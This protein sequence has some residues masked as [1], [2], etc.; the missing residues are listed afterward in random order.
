MSGGGEQADILPANYVVKDRWKVVSDPAGPREGLGRG[1]DWRP[2]QT[3][4]PTPLPEAG[5]APELICILLAVTI[6]AYT[7]GQSPSP[8]AP[9]HPFP[10]WVTLLGPSLKQ[11]LVGRRSRSCRALWG[12]RAAWG[13]GLFPL[14]T[15][16]KGSE[17]A[18]VPPLPQ[19]T[20]RPGFG[21]RGPAGCS[22]RSRTPSSPSTL[23]PSLVPAAGAT[24][25]DSMSQRALLL[26][27]RTSGCSACWEL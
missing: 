26:Q 17:C 23:L 16:E 4:A 21:E 3:A 15:L 2:V 1:E 6:L 10:C 5:G 13:R 18:C 20:E 7:C 14:W 25:R 22:H 11:L 19:R 9:S 24:R 27:P 8:S 12:R